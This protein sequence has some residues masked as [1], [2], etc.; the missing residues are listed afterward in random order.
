MIRFEDVSITYDGASAPVLSHVDLHVPEGE[1]VLVVGRTG[2][3]KST[4][5]RAVNGLVPHFT[6][7]TLSGRVTVAGRDTRT[8]PPRELADVVGVV[9]QDPMSGFV[10]DLVEDELAYGM[11]SIGLAPAVMRRRV[12][13]TLDLLGYPRSKWRLALNRADSKVGLTLAD[14]EKTLKA[15]IAVQ[16]PSSRDVSASV[17]RGVPI[18]LD[19]PHHAVSEAIRRFAQAEFPARAEIPAALRHDRRTFSLLRRGGNE[20]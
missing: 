11:E 19:D 3:G 5:L 2:S 8:H 1:L 10:T 4:L 14:V 7:G 17:N 6:G 16:V 12:E 18:V 13:E 9:P 20:R 15:Q